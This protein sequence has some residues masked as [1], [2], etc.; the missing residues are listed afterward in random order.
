MKQQMLR[1]AEAA[2]ILGLHPR[3]VVR[4]VES[5]E[6]EGARVGGLTLVRR[7][8]VERILGKSLDKP[9]SELGR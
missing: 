1:A 3:T 4:L 5:H 9:E 6:L 2:R 7:T 8:A